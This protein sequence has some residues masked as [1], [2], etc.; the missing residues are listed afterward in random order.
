MA[1]RSEGMFPVRR[2]PGTPILR[3]KPKKT[4]SE[5]K[6]DLNACGMKIGERDRRGGGRQ[7]KHVVPPLGERTHGFGSA[8]CQH[9]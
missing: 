6:F 7:G 1:F 5:V 3:N 4:E 8:K 9:E 2:R